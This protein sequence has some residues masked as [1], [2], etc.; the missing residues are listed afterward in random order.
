MAKAGEDFEKLVTRVEAVLAPDGAEVKHNQ[1]LPDS[2]TGQQR[3]VDATIRFTAGPLP[4]LI[5]IESRDRTSTEDVTW[6]EQLATKRHDIGAFK[7]IAVSST[8]FSKPAIAKAKVYGIE[9]RTVAEITDD[10]IK[11]WLKTLTLNLLKR[12]C[13]FGGLEVEL[14]DKDPALQMDTAMLDTFQNDQWGATIFQRKNQ[15]PVSLGGMLHDWERHGHSPWK[16][17]PVDGKTHTEKFQQPVG[18]NLLFLQTSKGLADIKHLSLTMKL[19]LEQIAIKA[20]RI[21]EYADDVQKLVQ[22]AEWD[23]TENGEII[24]IV[25]VNKVLTSG[26]LAMKYTPSAPAAAAPQA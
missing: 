25:S 22:L 4:V 18:Q 13:A 5:T 7:T 2:I 20:S 23:V 6:I 24:G 15:I 17:V 9:I 1:Y 16:H 26:A 10:D 11:G 19:R 12:D 21:L 3:Q 14:Y 8:G